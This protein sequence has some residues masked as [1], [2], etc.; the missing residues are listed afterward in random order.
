LDLSETIPVVGKT[1]VGAGEAEVAEAEE[2]CFS[3]EDVVATDEDFGPIFVRRA[4]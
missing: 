1:A 3:G 2:G 4:L